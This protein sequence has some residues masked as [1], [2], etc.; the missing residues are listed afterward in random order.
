MIVLGIDPGTV[1]C[2]IALYN[3]DNNSVIFNDVISFKNVKDGYLER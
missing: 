1:K 3:S 2:G